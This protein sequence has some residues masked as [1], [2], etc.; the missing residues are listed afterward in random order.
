MIAAF[1]A[2]IIFVLTFLGNTI[3]HAKSDVAGAQPGE[4]RVD[5]DDG[6]AGKGG[7]FIHTR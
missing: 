5:P 4:V 2:A 7:R 6:G 3:N 1:A